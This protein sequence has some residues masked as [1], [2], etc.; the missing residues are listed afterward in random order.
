MRRWRG[1]AKIGREVRLH[2]RSAIDLGVVVDVGEHLAL[3]AVR[4]G[5]R[6]GLFGHRF[7]SSRPRSAAGDSSENRGPSWP[8]NPL[9][10]EGEGAYA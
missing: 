7:S 1:D 5:G 2:G 10:E 4:L 3:L 6:G 8:E 9:A